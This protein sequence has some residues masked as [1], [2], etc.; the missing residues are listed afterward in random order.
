VLLAEHRLERVAGF[1]DLALGFSDGHVEVGPPAG[2]PPVGD[3]PA[4]GA[5][6][7]G[8][9]AGTR[10]RSRCGRRAGWEGPLVGTVARGPRSPRPAPRSSNCEASRCGRR[11]ARVATSTSRSAAARVVAVIGARGAGKT[12]L[13]AIAGVHDRS[14]AA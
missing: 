8:S 12:T 11:R 2:D 4:S 5:G 14:V 7:D 6:S 13:R 9:P 10:C 1:V 3:G